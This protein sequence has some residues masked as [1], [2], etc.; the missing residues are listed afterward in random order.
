MA[1][2]SQ[3]YQ[4]VA[5]RFR[6][7]SFVELV[8]QEAVVRSL[9]SALESGRV[10]HAFL[11]SGSRG[12][13]KTTSARI[14]ARALNCEVGMS[15]SPC[16]TCATCVSILAGSN[17]DVVEIDAASHNLVDDIRELCERVGVAS[18]GSRF[19]VYILDEVHM[20]TKN[21]FNAFLKTLE[22]PPRNVVFILATTE[23]HKVPETVRSRCQLIHFRRIDERDVVARLNELCAH[24]QV[25][26]DPAVLDEIALSCRGGMRD[27]ESMLERILPLARARQ[28]TFDLPAYRELMQRVGLDRA[29]EVVEH[30]LDGDAR[31]ALAFADEV[32][33]GGSDEREALAEVLDVLRAALLCAVDGAE[34]T[35]VAIRGALRER[36]VAIAARAEVGRLDAMIQAGLAGRERIRRTDDRR[37]VLEVSLVRMA[38]AGSLPTLAELAAAVASGAPIEAPSRVPLVA[39]G[40]GSVAPSPTSAGNDSG[41][42]ARFVARVRQDKPMLVATAAACVL[43]GPNEA[44]VVRIRLATPQKMHADR[45]A[46]PEVIGIFTHALSELCG[47]PVRLEVSATPAAA[48]PTASAPAKPPGPRTQA[49]LDRFDGDLVQP[50]PDDGPPRS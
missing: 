8:G 20:L 25:D 46:S 7:K 31:A 50:E 21:A 44:G 12:V 16:G 40:G 18:M 10:P 47:R 5:R 35:L 11:F 26:I 48:G 29:V 23:L 15:A 4:V 41:L 27:A 36:V 9:S 43:E 19:K 37:L 32:V 24:E 39:V 2:G 42:A 38:Q 13:G 33:G 34:S 14:L 17:A 6:P 45:L 1:N 22:E 30:M 28:A 49:V 3:P